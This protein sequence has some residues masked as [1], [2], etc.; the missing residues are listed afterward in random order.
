MTKQ[1]K[2]RNEK[3]QK[4]KCCGSGVGLPTPCWFLAYASALERLSVFHSL[5]FKGFLWSWGGESICCHLFDSDAWPSVF[6][7]LP[8]HRSMR[9]HISRA[10][11]STLKPPGPSLSLSLCLMPLL[12]SPFL[13]GLGVCVCLDEKIPVYFLIACTVLNSLI[14]SLFMRLKE[15]KC[16]TVVF[17][18]VCDK[19]CTPSWFNI[20]SILVYVWLC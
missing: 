8:T 19:L 10:V 20:V 3:K 5:Y 13:P 18:W 16:H 7:E 12:I 6:C 9:K 17:S 2:N 14:F 11:T 1:T 4:H 15:K